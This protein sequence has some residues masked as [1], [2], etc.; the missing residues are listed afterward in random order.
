M[1]LDMKKISLVFQNKEQEESLEALRET[2]VVHISKSNAE[3]EQLAE[4][5]NRKAKAE[6]ALG[7]ILTFKAPKK[8]KKA[9]DDHGERERRVN[10]N[11]PRRGRRITD[12]MGSEELEPY[13]L[14]AVMAPIRPELTDYMI[15]LSR[16][17][18][19]LEERLAFLAREQS[20]IIEWGEF[21]PDSVKELLS[22]G[23]PVFLYELLPEVFETIPQET[24]Y[25]KIT[26][27]KT[28][29]RLVVLDSP[30]PGIELFRLPEKS[31]S[32]IISEWEDLRDKLGLMNDKFKNLAD[33]Y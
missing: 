24:C 19:G 17:H 31:L 21:D 3:S 5:V 22:L 26:H 11:D 12:K 1:I 32:G 28:I 30:I 4:A 33:R 13:S 14:D 25:V 10:P 8:K 27:N 20:R 16:E 23:Q 18:Q 15:G 2:G 29:V 9:Q 7:L 6:E